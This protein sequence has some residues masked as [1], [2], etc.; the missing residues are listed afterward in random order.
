MKKLFL[1]MDARVKPGHD[2]SRGV[3]RRVGAIE[4]RMMLR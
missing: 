4:R 2:G 1:L 3:T